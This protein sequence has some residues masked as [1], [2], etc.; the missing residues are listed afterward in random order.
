VLEG[1]VEAELPILRDL[2]GAE[3]LTVNGAVRQ[4]HY[5][6]SGFGSYLRTD[7]SNDF[8]ADH[9][10]G[11]PQLGAD[12]VAAAA[13]D[14]IAR[15][16]RAQLRRAVPRLG[17]QLRA[18]DKSV[19]RAVDEL[20]RPR[21][22]AARPTSGP[23]RPTRP[24]SASC[25]RA[26][27]ACSTGLRLSVDGYRIEVKDYISTAPGGGQF[28]IDRCFAG[29]TA[30]CAYFDRNATT[31]RDHHSA[32][33]LAQPRPDPRQGHRLEADYRI[34]LSDENTLQLRG[35]ATYVDTLKSESFGDVVDRAGQTG[36]TVGLAAPQ[37][38]LNGT[39][40]FLA[41]RWSAT[42]QGRYID[43]GLYDA[44]RIG[45]EDSRYATTLP[46]SISDNHVASRFYVN[47]FGSVFVDEAKRSSCSA[48]S[49]TCSTP[50]RRRAGDAVLHQPGL[51]RHARPLLPGRRAHEAVRAP[52]GVI[53]AR[54]VS[55]DCRFAPM[56]RGMRPRGLLELRPIESRNTAERFSAGRPAALRHKRECSL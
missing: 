48:R 29:E 11:Q 2:P 28:L 50:T 23:R 1:Y 19:H 40:A 42:L 36:N 38:I 31:G 3:A 52:L 13:G 27:A 51:L 47:L 53:L 10:E 12:D 32:Q 34:P 35:I 14:A 26:T 46:N 54:T 45:P 4:T 15:H 37:W 55:F 8:D 20:P 25:S 56:P 18:G 49:A 44:Q 9:L 24:P 17:E 33:R 16:P 5:K 21:S 30:A 22:R 43:S 41:P 6:I 39:A 7:V